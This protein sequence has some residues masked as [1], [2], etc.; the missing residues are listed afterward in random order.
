MMSVR[1]RRPT[2][3]WLGLLLLARGVPGCPKTEVIEYVVEG[4]RTTQLFDLAAD[5][6][7][8]QDLADDPRYAEILSRLRTQLARHRDQLDDHQPDQGA[9]FWSNYT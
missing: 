5:P 3:L 2:V 6:W 4:Q 8:T 1:S 7:E 9:L